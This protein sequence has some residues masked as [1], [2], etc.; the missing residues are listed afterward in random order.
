LLA[1]IL[2]AGVVFFVRHLAELQQ[3]VELARRGQPLWLLAALAL[4]VTTYVSLASGWNLVLHRAGYAQS[5]RRLLPV[6]VSKLFA[7]QALPGAGISGNVLLIERLTG[8]GVPRPAAMAALLISMIGYYAAYAVLAVAMLLVL[9]SHREATPLLT[10]VVTT[11]LLVALAIPSLALWLRHRGSQPLPA[12][13]EK[14]LPLRKLLVVISEAPDRLVKDRKL[15]GRVTAHNS[16]IFLADA[17]TLSVCLCAVGEAL[18]PGVAFLALMS[19]SIAMTL[20]PVPL[21]LGSFEASCIAML[22]LLGIRIEPAVAATLLLRGFTLWLPL[23][24]GFGM[25]RHNRK[26]QT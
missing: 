5:L 22:T 11:F 13:V 2:G 16:L 7:D 24:L 10:G 25:I 26:Q 6:A 23:L 8:L 4:Q 21:G 17:A 20:T 14:I 18:R 12:S 3:F 9:W 1:A 19:G 15:I